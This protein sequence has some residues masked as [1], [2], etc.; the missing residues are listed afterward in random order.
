MK[1]QILRGVELVALGQ[2]SL[3]KAQERIT[4]CQ[5]CDGSASRSFESL[6]AL[7]LEK[8]G[9]TEYFVCSPVECPRCG[10]PILETTLVSV[11]EECRTAAM[12]TFE[13]SVEETEVVFV[14]EP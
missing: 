8:G 9:A 14:D 7:V 1:R 10:S 4:G 11:G 2:P 6:L 3:L 12:R 13:P 5:A